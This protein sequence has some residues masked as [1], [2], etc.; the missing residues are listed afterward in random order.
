MLSIFAT[1]AAQFAQHVFYSFPLL[2]LTRTRKIHMFM[3]VQRQGVFCPQLGTFLIGRLL[4]VAFQWE[5]L[6]P[7]ALVQA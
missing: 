7:E 5:K 3:W 6:L 2:H 4:S 1:E